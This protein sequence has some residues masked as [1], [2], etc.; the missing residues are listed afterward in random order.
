MT[1]TVEVSL[2]SGKTVSLQT[3]EDESAES[4][5]ARAQ[6]ALGAGKGR[7]L[8]GMGGVLDGGAPLKK[9]RPQTMGANVEPERLTFQIRRVEICSGARRRRLQAF[10]A[11][12][13]DGSALAWGHPR[14]GGD[15]S[16]VQDQLKNV[17]QIQ[18][19]YSSFAAILADGSVVTW[20]RAFSGGDSSAVRDQLKKVQQIQATRAAFAA[21]LADGSVATW[22]HSGFGGDSSAVQDQLKT[23]QHI[24]ATKC[25]FAAILADGS[26][27][28]WGHS[29]FGGDSSAVRGQL[30]DVQHI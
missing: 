6:K 14:W 15:S 5:S 3:H 22:G 12:L 21:I 16:A 10:V 29:G 20:G 11:I 26:V 4:L 30:K 17:Q 1:L 7:L 8:D 19:T 25:A 23:V 2:I 28:T 18:A 9:A 24:P 27:V 13:G